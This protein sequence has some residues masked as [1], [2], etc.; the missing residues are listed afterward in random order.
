MQSSSACPAI[1]TVNRAVYLQDN[2]DY[3]NTSAVVSLF[4]LYQSQ[5]ICSLAPPKLAFSQDGC[6]IPAFCSVVIGVL[7]QSNSA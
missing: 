4:A 1:D 5:Y 3:Q 2:S 7:I 6:K